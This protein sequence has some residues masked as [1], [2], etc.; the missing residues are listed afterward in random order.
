MILHDISKNIFTAK[1]YDGDPAPK[2]GWLSRIEYGEDCN[3]SSVELCTHT[4]THIDAPLHYL[5]DGDAIDEIPL[6][7]FYGA[8]TVVTIEGLLT[9]E[10]MEEILPFCKKR[11]LLR[12]RG[13]AFLTQSAAF[14]LADYGIRLIGTDG[15]SIACRDEEFEI[16]RE[17][18]LHN[19]IILE[20][21]ELAEIRDGDYTLAAFPIKLSGLEAAPVRAILLEQEKGI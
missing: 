2:S 16:H 6:S 4:G 15:L 17:L 18:L 11:L 9:G 3:L 21:L 7:V 19:V 14:V 1:L 13:Q 20:G 10:D 5:E 8:C 12:G